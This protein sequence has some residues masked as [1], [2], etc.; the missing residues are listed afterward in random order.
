MIPQLKSEI[1]EILSYL[2]QIYVE[3]S[4]MVRDIDELRHDLILSIDALIDYKNQLMRNFL[5]SSHWEMMMEQDCSNE[6]EDT[7]YVTMG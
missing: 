5:Q 1:A 7:A 2:A 6:R 3:E 4:D